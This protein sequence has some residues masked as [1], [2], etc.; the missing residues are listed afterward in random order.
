M[1]NR[2]IDIAFFQAT[3]DPIP[4]NDSV[5]SGKS[6][7]PEAP[8]SE[9]EIKRK[10]NA[11]IRKR[12]TNFGLEMLIPFNYFPTS[13]VKPAYEKR[14]ISNGISMLLPYF[15]SKKAITFLL[16]ESR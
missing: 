12:I 4:R 9:F 2:I 3:G 7:A 10:T 1:G 13:T 15:F 5:C 16:T 6:W 8:K 11:Q 14:F